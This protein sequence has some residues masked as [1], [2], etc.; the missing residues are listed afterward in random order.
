MSGNGYP[1]LILAPQGWSTGWGGS[2]SPRATSLLAKFRPSFP[3]HAE[4]RFLGINGRQKSPY[5]LIWGRRK[6]QGSPREV[7][8]GLPALETSAPHRCAQECSHHPSLQ[9][10]TQC[11]HSPG[12]SGTRRPRPNDRPGHPPFTSFLP[13]R[14]HREGAHPASRPQPPSPRTPWHE[15]SLLPPQGRLPPPAPPPS[16]LRANR[17]AAAARSPRKPRPSLQPHACALKRNSLS[18]SGGENREG[19]VCGR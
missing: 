17:S 11:P 3:T 9:Q 18:G 10:P 16:S 6:Q 1:A 12:P 4:A 15:K 8:E 5:S 13:S 2:G 19:P 14:H 7:R